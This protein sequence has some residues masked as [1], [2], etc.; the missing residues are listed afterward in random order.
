LERSPSFTMILWC[1]TSPLTADRLVMP[2]WC[3][4]EHK[5][6]LALQVARKPAPRLHPENWGVNPT[7]DLWTSALLMT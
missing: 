2:I 7:S 6:S 4:F 3:G 5:V 1:S